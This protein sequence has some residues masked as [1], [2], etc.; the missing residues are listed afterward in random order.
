MY[1]KLILQKGRERPVLLGHP[2]IFSGAVLIEP[3]ASEGDIVSVCDHKQ[4][5]LAH[6]FYSPASQIRCRLFDFSTQVSTPFVASYWKQRISQAVAL[7]RRWFDGNHTNAWRL[8]HAEGDRMPG[9]IADVYDQ[10]VV[11]QLLIRGSERILPILAATLMESGFNH[12]YL[13]QKSISRHIEGLQQES[14]WLTPPPSD[15]PIRIREHGCLFEVDPVGGQKTGFF[16]DQR[17]NRWLVGQ[18]SQNRRVLNAFS[19]T[20][21]FSIYALKGGASL[22]DSVDSSQAA[23][24]QAQHNAQLNNLEFSHRAITADCFDFLKQSKPGEY[25]LM[26]LDP[27]AFAK[28]AGAVPNALRGYKELNL[29]ALRKIAP[30]GLLFSFS[31][32][33]AIEPQLFRKM[34]FGAAVDARRQVRLL[35]YLGQPA[36]HPVDIGHPEGEYLKGWLMAVE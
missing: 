23:V 12:I 20:G 1:P 11:V 5:L 35:H 25:D 19:Y 28:K 29:E 27:P 9:V 21:G 31:C 22:V 8:L 2:W 36:D 7:R 17:E 15:Y 26:V 34:L 24:D 10:T 33:Q 18:N 3:Q 30:G 6:G 4:Q 13:K 32:S 16:L 14:G